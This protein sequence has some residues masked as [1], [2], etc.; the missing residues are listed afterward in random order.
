MTD[1]IDI[2]RA[3]NPEWGKYS[4]EVVADII[5]DGRFYLRYILG[6]ATNVPTAGRV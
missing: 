4:G 6:L 1:E 5:L 2:N 3:A